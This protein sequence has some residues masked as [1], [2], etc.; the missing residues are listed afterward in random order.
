MN[1]KKQPTPRGREFE[2][3]KRLVR[4]VGVRN[5]RHAMRLV[6]QH[7]FTPREVARRV[8]AAHDQRE[9]RRAKAGAA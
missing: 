4:S 7:R 9:R 1:R 5:A 8:L 6:Q 3:F 2:K